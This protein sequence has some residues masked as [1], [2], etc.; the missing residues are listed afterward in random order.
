MCCVVFWDSP[1]CVAYGYLLVLFCNTKPVRNIGHYS[2][3]KHFHDYIIIFMMDLVHQ[4]VYSIVLYLLARNESFH[5]ISAS[6]IT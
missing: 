5:E 3:S 6:T 1:S 4:F 2:V